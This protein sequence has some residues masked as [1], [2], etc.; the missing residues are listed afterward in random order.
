MNKNIIAIIALVVLSFGVHAQAGLEKAD[1]LYN[2]KAYSEAIPKYE[3]LLKKDSNNAIVLS[4]LGDCYRLTNNAAG[5]VLCYGKLAESGKAESIQK[6][7]L[8]QAYMAL[9]RYDEAKKYSAQ[10]I[11]CKTT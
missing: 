7:Y 2:A 1:K 5:Q 9:G 4:K 10:C 6:L 3:K 11:E 8:G